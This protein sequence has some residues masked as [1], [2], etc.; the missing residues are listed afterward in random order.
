V[1][2]RRGD[3]GGKLDGRGGYAGVFGATK[4]VRPVRR[5]FGQRA[6]LRQPSTHSL[7]KG[8]TQFPAPG[9]CRR[10]VGSKPPK[11]NTPRPKPQSGCRGKGAS[12][13]QAPDRAA[14]GGPH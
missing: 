12:R 6:P 2:D 13:S 11:G 8:E 1:E 4:Q 14:G 5:H 7:T 10:S 3:N 9:S